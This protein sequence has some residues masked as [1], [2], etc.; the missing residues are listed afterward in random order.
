MDV[1]KNIWMS[2]VR[3]FNIT[4]DTN[5]EFWGFIYRNQI[6]SGMYKQ[7]IEESI[8]C[9][10]EDN[11]ERLQVCVVKNAKIPT[12]IKWY[13]VSLLQK[14]LMSYYNWLSQAM[15]P[16]PSTHLLPKFQYIPTLSIP[17]GM[18]HSM[19]NKN[20][21]HATLPHCRFLRQGHFNSY[22]KESKFKFNLNFYL[23][24]FVFYLWKLTV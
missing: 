5:K 1:S 19:S 3:L 11:N 6:W 7:W 23:D 2:L 17:K 18:R 12:R 20:S 8:I 21:N 16:V 14:I 24:C 13:M 4:H 9:A 22:E 15:C 10:C